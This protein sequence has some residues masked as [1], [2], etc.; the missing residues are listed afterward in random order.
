MTKYILYALTLLYIIPSKAQQAPLYNQYH[1]APL[2]YNPSYVGFND[3]VDVTLIR[4]QKWG[5]YGEGFNANSLSVGTLLKDNKSGLGISLY[6]DYVGIT[7]KLNAHLLYAYRIQLG[8]KANLRAGVAAG[9]V[10]NRIDFSNVVVTDPNDPVVVNAVGDRKTMFDMNVGLNF[11]YADLRVGVSMPQVLGSKLLYAGNNLSYYTLERQLVSNIGYSWYLNREKGLILNPEAMVIY[12]F[13]GAPLQYS[14]NLMFEMQKIAWVGVGYKSNYAMSFNVGVNLVKNLKFGLAYDFMINDVAT[15]SNKPNAE[16]ML[17][18][19]IPPKVQQ[20]QDNSE[21]ERMLAEQKRIMDSLNNVIVTNDANARNQ[22]NQLE[23]E[24]QVLEDSLKKWPKNTTTQV[25]P[26]DTIPEIT[27]EDMTS[28]PADYFIELSGKDT[29]NGYYVITGAFA[30]KSNADALIRKIKAKYPN[31][32]IIQN[33]RNNLYYVL[34]Y[35]STEK[36]EGLGYASYKAKTD[37]TEET[38][39]LHYVKP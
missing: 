30:Q 34:L 10:D 14:A 7:S 32:R 1:V 33:K 5:N 22:I 13:P 39:V 16:I 31:A 9:V 27:P 38:W 8:E 11:S 19:S 21:F 26:V 3:G 18:Y 23:N 28:N 29:P 17:K 6:S 4:N 36:N 12:S 35:H 15:Y 37:L 20:V 2:I 25:V 24:N